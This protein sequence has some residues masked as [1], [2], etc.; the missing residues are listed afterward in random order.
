MRLEH[1]RKQQDKGIDLIPVGDFSYYD[2]MLDTSVMFGLVPERFNYQPAGPVPLSVYFAIARGQKGATASEMT[3]WL[4]TNYHYIVPELANAAPVFTE[5]K[6]LQAYLEA[7]QELGIEGKPVI[8]G[9]GVYDIHSPRIPDVSEMLNMIQRA[10]RV[11]PSDLFWVNPDCGLKTRTKE[12]SIAALRQM[13]EAAQT[14]RDA[15]AVSN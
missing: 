3:K 12:E 7:K 15:L 11:L 6:P 1:L 13:V 4:D 9:L 2:H 8:I 5:N 10:L 14:A